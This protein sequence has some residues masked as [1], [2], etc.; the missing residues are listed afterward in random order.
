MHNLLLTVFLKYVKTHALNQGF[1][2]MDRSINAGIT[3]IVLG[4]IL[5]LFLPIP[6]SI[7]TFIPLFLGAV[8]AII[9]FRLRALKDGLIVALMT[10]LFNL[11]ILSTIEYAALYLA[12]EPLESSV[13]I[14]LVFTPI[15]YSITAL[16]AGVVG[17][18]LTR[19]M[20]PAPEAPPPLPP[21]IPPV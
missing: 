8:F 2:K 10:Y 17:V 1:G 14:L 12:D 19:R 6:V 5:T 21:A 9:I 15:V 13:D 7:L 16:I 3:G 11:G 18:W 4:F 20:K